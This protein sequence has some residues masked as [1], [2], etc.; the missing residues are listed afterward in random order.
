MAIVDHFKDRQDALIKQ[1]QRVML[2]GRNAGEIWRDMIWMLACTIANQL[3]SPHAEDRERLYMETARKYS[4]GALREFAKVFAM[5]CEWISETEQGGM[6]ADYLGDT[7][8]R[9]GLGNSFGGQFFTPYHICRMMTK[10]NRLDSTKAEIKKMGWA[11]V[12]DPACGAGATLVAFAEHCMAE[13]IDYQEDVLFV[14]Q[15]IDSTPALMCYIQL[16][17]LGCAGY[18]HIGDSL[19]KPQTAAL[20]VG[21]RGP[22]TWYTPMYHMGS[23]PLRRMAAMTERGLRDGRRKDRRD[24]E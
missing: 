11:S 12:T 24:A 2:C 21:D 1:I 19:R 6:Y 22:Q 16:S 8:M 9:L 17:L 4:A 10:I 3:P 14:G 7:F 20:L 18:V 13:G 5:L 15:D 23:W